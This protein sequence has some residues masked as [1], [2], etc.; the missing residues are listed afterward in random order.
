MRTGAAVLRALDRLGYTVK[1]VTLTKAGEWLDGGKVRRP[2]QALTGID[3]VFLALHGAY[4]EDGTVQRFLTTHH[5]PYTGS[6]ALASATAFHKG[7]TNERMAHAGIRTA[8]NFI[9]T[10]DTNE[11][12]E[13]LQELL[14]DDFDRLVIKPLQSGSSIDVHVGVTVSEAVS[15]LAELAERYEHI[16][17][18]QYLSGREVTVGIVDGLRDTTHYPL[19]P[20]EILPPDDHAFY[21]YD[22]K[23]TGV[24]RLD[25]PATLSATV[26]DA[27]LQMAQEAHRTLDLRHYSRSDFILKGDT[28]YFLEVN[29]L[30]G[31]TEHSLLPRALDAV[32]VS[33]DQ[34]VDHLLQQAAH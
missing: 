15:I 33:Y 14:D 31:L 29:T 6:R 21:S 12:E 8:R 3:C 19:P 13:S 22:A 23:Y 32:G 11:V 28:P 5:I 18:E 17:V 16:M 25:C 34:F 30:P 1:D 10:P 2:E 27:L 26:R 20:V 4:G 9:Y 24:T 7:L